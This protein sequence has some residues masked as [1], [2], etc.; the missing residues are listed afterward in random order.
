MGTNYYLHKKES[1]ERYHI[2]KLSVG[3][4]PLFQAQ[5]VGEVEIASF[6][7]WL[8]LLK[9]K[10]AMIIDEYDREIEVE[11]FLSEVHRKQQEAS[12]SH[13]SEEA[14]EVTRDSEG[15]EFMEKEFV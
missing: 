8:C 12:W 5:R 14:E 4:K 11:E 9:E 7:D 1:R 3:W 6:Q 13:L 10:E 15:Y 2:C